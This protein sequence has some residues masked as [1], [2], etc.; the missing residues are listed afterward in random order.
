ML[1]K[2]ITRA[3]MSKVRKRLTGGPQALKPMR[4]TKGSGVKNGTGQAL[5]RR[6]Q[7]LVPRQN[8]LMSPKGNVRRSRLK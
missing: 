3:K 7:Y 5:K 6:K 1:T 8:P 2:I 4:P